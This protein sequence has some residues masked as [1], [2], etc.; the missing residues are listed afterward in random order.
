MRVEFYIIKWL[1]SSK[2]L[3]LE[4]W[5][6]NIENSIFLKFSDRAIDSN[7]DVFAKRNSFGRANATSNEIGYINLKIKQTLVKKENVEEKGSQT[8]L[9]RFYVDTYNGVFL[10]VD[11]RRGYRVA[12][13]GKK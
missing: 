5:Q 2:I 4:R 8:A 12:S 6:D 9:L 11:D 1:I 13:R 7:S 3:L 10:G